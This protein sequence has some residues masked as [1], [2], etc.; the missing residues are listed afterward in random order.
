MF[1][2]K[3]IEVLLVPLMDLVPLTVGASHPP[4]PPPGKS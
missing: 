4:E 3:L 1:Y 2:D